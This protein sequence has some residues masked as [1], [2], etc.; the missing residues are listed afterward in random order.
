MNLYLAGEHSIKN[1]TLQTHKGLYILETYYYAKSNKHFETVVEN[2]RDVLLDSG[3]FTFMKGKAQQTDFDQYTLDYA[4]FIKKHG[5]KHFFELDIDQ[6]VGLEKVEQLR[7]LLEQTTGL[8]CIPVWHKSR[9]LKYWHK[10]CEQ[11]DYVSFS[12]S[13]KNNSSEWVKAAGGVAA[14]AKLV[15]IAKTYNT[16]THAL[17]YSSLRN[18]QFLKCHSVDSTTWLFGNMG[19]VVYE[20]TGNTLLKHRIPEKGRLK[21]LKTAKHNFNEW[22]KYQQYAKQNL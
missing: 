5:I 9:G 20:F 19:G 11:Y 18:L 14:M 7:D 12:A 2:S 17:E 1:G 22:I 13:A 8:P 4:A 16:K 15:E 10:I 21:S 3:A 6:V